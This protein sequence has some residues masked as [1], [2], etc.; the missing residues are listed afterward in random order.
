MR[1]IL[2]TTKNLVSYSKRILHIL[3]LICFLSL[4]SFK[5]IAQDSEIFKIGTIEAKSGEKVSGKLIIE[6]GIDEGTFIPVSI[7]KGINPGPV[8][9]LNAGLHGTEYVPVITLQ[10]LFKKINPKE[11]SGTLVLIH[12]ANIPSFK[13]KKVYESPIDNKNPNRSFPGIK[14]GTQSER[15]AYTITN[16]IFTKSDYYIDLHGGEF[17]EHIIDY[18][19][20]YYGCPKSDLCKK[21]KMLA[22][23][24]GNK[25][26]IPDKIEN[27]PDTI[28]G[29]FSDIA[30]FHNGVA[31]I[32]NE[33]GDMGVVK[34]KELE[35]AMDGLINTM[36]T[37]GMLEG[38]PIVNNSPIYLTE[39]SFLHCNYN[40]IFYPLVNKAQYISKG[41][42][43]G[44]TTD[45]WGNILEEY[46]SPFTGIVVVIKNAPSINKGDNVAKVAKVSDTF[47]E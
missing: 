17:V 14:D 43:L 21:S 5:V 4:F 34:P 32:T 16:E 46:K 6:E 28:Q 15:I 24:I 36:K 7:I 20:F 30:A 3:S 18:V 9:T 22:H 23:A 45:Y 38:E 41:T 29:T 13:A 47:N 35:T 10:K 8:L 42:L 25:Y 40:G 12:V 39:E 33:W 44:Y 27:Y 31:S 19:Y 26:L 1:L 2:C 11:L 37:I